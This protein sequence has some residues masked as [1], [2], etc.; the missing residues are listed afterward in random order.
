MSKNERGRRG[1]QGG[2]LAGQVGPCGLER[3]L[4]FYPEGD[5]SPGGLWAEEGRDLSQVFKARLLC[6]GKDFPPP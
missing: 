1:G 2:D 5:G 3:G 4:G 6:E